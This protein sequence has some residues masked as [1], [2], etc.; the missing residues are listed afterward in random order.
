M[1]GYRTD[2]HFGVGGAISLPSLDL[3][4][5]CKL[6]FGKSIHITQLHSTMRRRS[7]TVLSS[8]GLGGGGGDFMCRQSSEKP[9]TLLGCMAFFSLD[10]PPFLYL[11]HTAQQRSLVLSET[12]ALCLHAAWWLQCAGRV[13]GEAAEHWGVR[14]VAA[15]KVAMCSVPATLNGLP[16]E[17]VCQQDFWVAGRRAGELGGA[18][19]SLPHSTMWKAARS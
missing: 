15:F 5:T 8:S 6:S 13:L 2:I 11:N 10:H 9:I 19:A 18:D 3:A 14:G 16:A 17:K 7:V 1:K 12:A 4:V